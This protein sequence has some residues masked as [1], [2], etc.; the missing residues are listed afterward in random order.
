MRNLNRFWTNLIIWVSAY[1]NFLALIVI[2]VFIL[3]DKES[4]EEAKVNFKIAF[5]VSA[6][7]TGLSLIMGLYDNVFIDL[8]NLTGGWFKFYS[9]IINLN[10]IFRSITFIVMIVLSLFTNVF[11]DKGS[12]NKNVSSLEEGSSKEDEFQF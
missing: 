7:F 12:S 11:K 10:A 8:G 9:V 6:I 1:V 5:V 4:H 3:N 2:G